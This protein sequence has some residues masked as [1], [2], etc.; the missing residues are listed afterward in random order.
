MSLKKR[1][2][3]FLLF[4]LIFFTSSPLVIFYASGYK[5]NWKDPLSSYFIQKTGMLI[6][7]SEPAEAKIFLNEKKQKNISLGPDIFSGGETVKTP[8]KI[9]NLLPG[10][11][12]LR[13]ELE[14]YWPWER[15]IKIYSEQITHVLDVHLFKRESPTISLLTNDEKIE[16]SPNGKKILLLPSAKILEIKSGKITSV[17]SSTEEFAYWSPDSEK[18]I[19]PEKII[20]LKSPEKN[21]SLKDLLGQDFSQAKWGKSNE[22][23]FYLYKN[24]LNRLNLQTKAVET[25]LEEEGI[26]SFLPQKNQITAIISRGNSVVLKIISSAQKDSGKE[27]SLPFSAE[28]VFINEESEFLNVLDKKHSI[29]YLIKNNGETF[30]TIENCKYADWFEKN[31]L[32]YGNDFEIW[33]LNL[34]EEENRLLTRVS[35]NKILGVNATKTDN[36][37]FYFT[38]KTASVLTWDKGEEKIQPTELLKLESIVS[39][40]FN[41]ENG[42]IYFLSEVESQKGLYQLPVE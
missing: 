6:V 39:P 36:Y 16:F 25:V 18:I 28:Y 17:S 33:S 11:Y 8:A 9:K 42:I 22:E 37:I 23:I 38:K 15:R 40:A 35:G 21:I 41:S 7:D 1:K 12:D 14:G 10:S 30:K 31:I 4:I 20:N 3:I 29:L 13:V 24:K 19:F 26:I 5:L 27:T 34:S 32:F 2:I